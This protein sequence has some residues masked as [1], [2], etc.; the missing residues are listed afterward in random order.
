M[1]SVLQGSNKAEKPRLHIKYF[2]K[3]DERKI[4]FKFWNEKLKK[5]DKSIYIEPT[6][7]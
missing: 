6:Q 3:W 5:T 4:P 2:H 7:K 1:D